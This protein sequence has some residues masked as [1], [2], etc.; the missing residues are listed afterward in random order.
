MSGIISAR[1]RALALILALAATLALLPIP[2][3]SVNPSFE[4][5]YLFVSPNT[6][7][8]LNMAEA[9]RLLLSPEHG[10]YRRLAGDILH[11]LGIGRHQVYDALGDWQGGVE[12]SLFV[13]VKSPA[14]RQTLRCAVAWF[15]LVAHQKCVL[16][17]HR[18]PHGDDVMAVID[19]PG[20]SLEQVR[21]LLD[22]HGIRDRTLFHRCGG[23]R[24]VVLAESEQALRLVRIRGVKC[25]FQIGEAVFLGETTRAGASERYREVLRASRVIRHVSTGRQGW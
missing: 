18:D 19:M 1:H 24:A 15:G 21:T 8:D 12:N 16:A 17:F 7:E 4:T 14:D 9:R 5:A 6:R 13:E 10:R 2:T 23:W 3:T 22:N 11:Q 20:R 25:R